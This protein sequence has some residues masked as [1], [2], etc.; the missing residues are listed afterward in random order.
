MSEELLKVSAEQAVRFLQNQNDQLRTQLASAEAALQAER[1][2]KFLGTWISIQNQI[3][4]ENTLVILS[5]AGTPH[6]HV[7]TRSRNE[8]YTATRRIQQSWPTHWMLAPEPPR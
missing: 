3:P 8:Y 1:T 2:K 6:L 5:R 7:A 4:E